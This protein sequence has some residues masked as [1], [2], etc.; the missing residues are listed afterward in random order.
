MMQSIFSWV[1]EHYDKIAVEEAILNSTEISGTV[2]RLPMV[3]G[4]GDPL[5]RF[6]PLLKRFDD[7]RSSI[8]LADD[9]AAW[10]GP[11]GYVENIAHAIALAATS[12]Q[13]AGR[14]YNVCQE[15]IIPG[16][17]RFADHSP[18]VAASSAH[19][20]GN[21]GGPIDCTCKPA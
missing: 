18:T 12:N 8:L 13:V 20:W 15:P 19:R 7:G 4:P 2:L 10:R 6:F 5:H 3:Y 11:R 17:V 16:K 14:V 21:Q 1:D 9:L